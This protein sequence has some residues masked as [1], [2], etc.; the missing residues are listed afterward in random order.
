MVHI[1][2]LE[3]NPASCILSVYIK[4]LWLTFVQNEQIS[5]MLYSEV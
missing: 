2:C 4:I 3:V 1:V 5:S